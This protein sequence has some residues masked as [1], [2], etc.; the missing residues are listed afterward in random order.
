MTHNQGVP[1]SSPGGTTSSRKPTPN[2]VGF[3]IP[4]AKAGF[5]LALG[6]ECKHAVGQRQQLFSICRSVHYLVQERSDLTQV[7]PH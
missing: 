1:G 2:G 3:C 7:G 6:G 5:T 4:K